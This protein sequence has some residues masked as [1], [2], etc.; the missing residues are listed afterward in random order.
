MNDEE[1]FFR[2]V[3][4]VRGYQAKKINGSRYAALFTKITLGGRQRA[5]LSPLR[6]F[7][8]D[9]ITEVLKRTDWA[10]LSQQKPTIQMTM[11]VLQRTMDAIG[12]ALIGENDAME[13]FCR[14]RGGMALAKAVNAEFEEIRVHLDDLYNGSSRSRN[15]QKP[16][17]T[18]SFGWAGSSYPTMFARHCI[19]V[20]TASF[21]PERGKLRVNAP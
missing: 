5:R 12:E 16:S 6:N 9:K 13:Q 18:R 7:H 14:A 4:Q 3:L 19:Q 10:K 15:A 17:A 8:V 21:D 1:R 20:P 11:D 2:F